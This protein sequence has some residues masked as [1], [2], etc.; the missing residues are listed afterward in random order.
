MLLMQYCECFYF[1]AG[2]WQSLVGLQEDTSLVC[3]YSQVI[4]ATHIE[5]FIYKLSHAQVP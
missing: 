2:T 1:Y 4:L 5:M 3:K